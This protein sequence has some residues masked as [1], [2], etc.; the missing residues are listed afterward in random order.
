MLAQICSKCIEY[1]VWKNYLGQLTGDNF[2]EGTK[3]NYP[4]ADC[5]R[6]NF[7]GGNCLGGAI[8][9]VVITQGGTCPRTNLK[10]FQKF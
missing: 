4:G 6:G 8:I 1:F 7:A 9:R 3:D 2:S 10:E 5:P